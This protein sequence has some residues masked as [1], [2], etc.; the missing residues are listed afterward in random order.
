MLMVSQSSYLLSILLF[1]IADVVADAFAD[2]C[3]M[4]WENLFCR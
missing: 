4:V 1:A 3:A 2:E